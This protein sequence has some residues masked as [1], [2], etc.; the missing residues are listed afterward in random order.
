MPQVTS[1]AARNRREMG[2]AGVL[3]AKWLIG[4]KAISTHAGNAT[5]N[6]S[7]HFV[8]AVRLGSNDYNS[9]Q[10]A[11]RGR[12][13]DLAYGP[14]ARRH[15]IFTAGGTATMSEVT[16]RGFIEAAAASGLLAANAAGGTDFAFKNNV[17]DPL[18]AGQELPTFKFELEK[19]E[20]KVIGKSSGKEAT[21]KQLPIS[22]G[23]AGVSMILEPVA[24]AE[25]HWHA[26]SAEWAFVPRRGTC[27]TT[28]V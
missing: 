20:G 5:T 1:H 26:T 27:R 15:A 17:P 21:V 14:R 25:L 16:R 12:M 2:I 13:P 6:R 7:M 18:L 22:K 3:V 24:T 9:P 23:I 11:Y 8:W 4:G 28:V 19:S 10:T